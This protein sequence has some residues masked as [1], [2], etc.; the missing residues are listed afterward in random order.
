LENIEQYG[1]QIPNFNSKVNLLEHLL[2]SNDEMSKVLVFA[3]TKKMADV[4]FEKME[5]KF[6]EKLGIIHSS[7]S[8]NYRFDTVNR[9]DEGSIR[10]LIATDIIARGLDVSSV[11]HVINFDLTDTAEK[12]IHRIGR[13]G[14]SEKKGIAIAFVSEEEAEYLEQIENLMNLKLPILELPEE[15]ELS[16]ELIPLEV[17]DDYVP[18]N[19][20]KAKQHEPSGPAFHEKSDKNKKV[21]NKIR[22]VEAMKMKYGKPQKRKPKKR[23]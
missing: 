10:C 5:P 13:T 18:F 20:H 23:K 12:Y 8:Q 22:K 3:K 17:P 4:L 16:D 15:V 1:Y 2:N 11:T 19:H 21:N 7:K 9:F 14:R 6:S